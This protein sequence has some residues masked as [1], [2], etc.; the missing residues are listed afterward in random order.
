MDSLAIDLWEG[1]K[2]GRGREGEGTE[3]RKEET[4]RKAA[5]RE[6]ILEAQFRIN[7]KF[8]SKIIW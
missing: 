5:H 4:K 7:S 3:G 8:D 1:R 6:G 2:E